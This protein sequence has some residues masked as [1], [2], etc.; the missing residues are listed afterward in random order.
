MGTGETPV[1]QETGRMPVLQN[2]AR[3]LLS[4]QNS[5]GGWPTFCRGWGQLPFDQ[6]APDLTAHALRALHRA[7][8]K[9]SAAKIVSALQRGMEYLHR[10]QR[11]DGAWLPLWFGNQRQSEH[12]NPVLGTA[13]VLRAFEEL[14]IYDNSAQNGVNYLLSAQNP[15]GGWGGDCGVSSSVEETALAVTALA[16]WTEHPGVTATLERGGGYL[17]DVVECGGWDRPTPIGL[18]FARL[19]YSERLY[20]VIWTLEAL[21]R[22]QCLGSLSNGG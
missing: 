8:Q 21:G 20:P 18:Y 22:L 13:R 19:W 17:V 16:G 12:A 7:V 11:P 15:D 10:V 3:W 1:L 9:G 2:A 4:L 6:S 5:D 14:R